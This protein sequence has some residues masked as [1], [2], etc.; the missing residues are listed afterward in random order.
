M[1]ASERLAA[2]GVLQLQVR[3]LRTVVEALERSGV[4]SL[5]VKGVLL[6][7]QLYEDPV[8]RR[9]LD[10]DLLIR[11]RDFF[12]ALRIARMN[13]F[14]IQWDSKMLGS[15]NF[16]TGG[17]PTDVACTMG[18]PGLS[19]SSVDRMLSR[20]RRTNEPLGFEH[21]QIDWH[22]HALLMVVDAFKDKLVTKPSV[23]E[24]LLRIAKSP[25]FEP[26][27]LVSR[28]REAR[29]EGVTSI[30]AHWLATETGSAEW[31]DVKARLGRVRPGYVHA[32]LKN[33]EHASR[34][35]MRLLARAGSD[36]PL[37]RAWAMAL[38]VI[39]T[40]IYSARHRVLPGQDAPVDAV[41]RE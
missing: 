36:Q 31:S 10:V 3:A 7:H 34:M 30:V 23:R 20:A 41:P 25:R 14:G 13:E 38:G 19:A 37:R 17:V 33:V 2:W 39:G 32:Y 16:V 15:V 1:S 5:P 29:L 6:V 26:A 40:A 8:E 11:P 12:R 4:P 27:T 9:F 18:P 28:A 35:R 24:D 21:W 22:D